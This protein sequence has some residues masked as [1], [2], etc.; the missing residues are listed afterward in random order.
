[1]SV[2]RGTQGPWNERDEDQVDLHPVH[3]HPTQQIGCI[4]R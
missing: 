3:D 4:A 2:V 1:L